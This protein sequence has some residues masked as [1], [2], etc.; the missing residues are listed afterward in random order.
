MTEETQSAD[1][2][3]SV[4]ENQAVVAT[5]TEQPKID[6]AEKPKEEVKSTEEVTKD[7]PTV[8]Y[9]DFVLP[10]GFVLEDS[11]LEKIAPIFKEAGV[12]KE[13]AQK[14]LDVHVETMQAYANKAE[15]ARLEQIDSWAEAAKTDKQIGGDKF[16][17]TVK[18]AKVALEKFGTPALTELLKST[19][20]EN[21]PEIIR[22]LSKVG[23]LTQE[24]APQ[25]TGKSSTS[26]KSILDTFYPD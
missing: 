9:K 21:N 5:P 6:Q 24:D 10:E 23:S 12:S 2:A 7:T 4:A 19:G 14:M 26:G 1:I 11:T 13:L 15:L 18:T 16:S 22:L 3:Q 17:E 20:I 8:E 25:A